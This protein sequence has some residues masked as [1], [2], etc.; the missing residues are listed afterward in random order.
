MFA[1]LEEKITNEWIFILMKANFVANEFRRSD[2]ADVG[3][4]NPLVFNGF[5]QPTN[6]PTMM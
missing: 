5:P 2:A 4:Q 1:K 3:C 6:Q